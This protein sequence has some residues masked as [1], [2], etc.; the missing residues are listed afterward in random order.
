EVLS[1][2]VSLSPAPDALF[3]LFSY[4]TGGEKKLKAR[5]LS[6]GEDPDGDAATIDVLAALHKFPGIRPDPEAFIEAL[7]PLQPRVYSISSSHRCNP[8]RVALTVDAVR[9]QI[10]KRTR[11]GVCS[12]FLGGRV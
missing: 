10:N 3:Q 5:A 4:I 12:T 11:L 2:Q 7:D 6:S 8:G 9:Y 1:D